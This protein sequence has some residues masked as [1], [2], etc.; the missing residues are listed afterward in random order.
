M[1]VTNYVLLVDFMFSVYFSK[2]QMAIYFNPILYVQFTNLTSKIIQQTKLQPLFQSLYDVENNA[3]LDLNRNR[4]SILQKVAPLNF[5][6]RLPKQLIYKNLH[7]FKLKVI[8]Q[9]GICFCQNGWV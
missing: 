2:R 9:N 8:E 4:D 6:K 1:R 7:L 5:F 3:W